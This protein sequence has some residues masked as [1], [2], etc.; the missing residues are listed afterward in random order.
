V[1]RQ[2]KNLSFTRSRS[3]ILRL[4][5]FIKLPFSLAHHFGQM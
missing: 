5:K 4:I 3:A 1:L 2:E